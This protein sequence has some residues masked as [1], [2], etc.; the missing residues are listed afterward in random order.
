MFNKKIKSWLVL[1]LLAIMVLSGHYTEA[2]AR[3]GGGGGRSGGGSRSYSSSRSHGHNRGPAT[4]F[5]NFIGTVCLGLFGLA[6]SLIGLENLNFYRLL[7]QKSG[8]AKA[9]LDQI[10]RADPSWDPEH[11]RDRVRKTYFSVQRAWMAR[12]QDLAKEFISEKL[13]R[14]HKMMTDAMIARHEKN[15]LDE[16]ELIDSKAVSVED[17]AGC[18]RDILWIY[19]TGAMID[20]KINEDT[21]Y[22]ISGDMTKKE[23]FNEL[24]KF[25]KNAEGEWVLDEIKNKANSSEFG[26]F[27]AVSEM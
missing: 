19:I 25:I 27:K 12:N 20:Y 3:A 4:P 24:W 9:M 2:S 14:M 6:F 21:G 7:K 8:E 22:K 5:E 17:H 16:I 15:I 26:K 18:D 13:Y 10:K 11:I 1:V 23:T